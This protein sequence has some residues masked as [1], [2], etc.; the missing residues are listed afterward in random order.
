MHR[1]LLVLV[2]IQLVR[3]FTANKD[4]YRRAARFASVSFG[5]SGIWLR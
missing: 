4:A 3:I 1:V 2:M 5:I